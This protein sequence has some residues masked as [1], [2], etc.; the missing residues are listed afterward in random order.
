[1]RPTQGWDVAL[2][3]SLVYIVPVNGDSCGMVTDKCPWRVK[4]RRPL[5]SCAVKAPNVADDRRLSPGFAGKVKKNNA[6]I[7]QIFVIIEYNLKNYFVST[8]K[9]ER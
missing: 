9:I 3:M 4:R 6:I 2:I 5:A 7:R 1:M 8:R